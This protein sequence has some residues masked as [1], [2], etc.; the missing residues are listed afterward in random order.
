MAEQ[1]IGFQVEDTVTGLVISTEKTITFQP[2][3]VVSNFAATTDGET[4]VDWSADVN[5]AGTLYVRMYADATTPTDAEIKAGTGAIAGGWVTVTGAGTET[6]EI[7]GLTA[8]TDYELFALLVS[9]SSAPDDSAQ[10][11]DGFTTQ[12]PASGGVNFDD[13]KSIVAADS[14]TDTGTSG[15]TV[16]VIGTPTNGMVILIGL[17]RTFSVS[18]SV[19]STI[20][21]ESSSGGTSYTDVGDAIGGLVKNN[22]LCRALT[23]L[24][25]STEVYYDYAPQNATTHFISAITL[26]GV[27][28]DVSN[29]VHEGNTSSNVTTIDVTIANV[30]AGSLLLLGASIE[31]D[32]TSDNLSASGSVVDPIEVHF[33]KDVDDAQTR[34][35]GRVENATAGNHTFTLTFDTA[36][37]VALSIIE[38]LPA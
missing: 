28:Q 27:D 32:R 12:T 4:A 29:I 17:A 36:T 18:Q 19:G 37:D 14:S 1:L 35:I 26:S 9:D 38:V 20:Y 21:K 6:G 5:R 11:T 22:V 34:Y 33:G 10:A 2:F 23:G 7:T 24:T 15:N 16:D 8:G 25:G 3:P 30:T 13:F 31:G